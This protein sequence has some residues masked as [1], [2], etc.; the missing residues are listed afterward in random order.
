MI[1]TLRPSVLPDSKKLL[2][3]P[4]GIG[5]TLS[6]IGLVLAN[7]ILI[8]L[9]LIVLAVFPGLP[10]FFHLLFHLLVKIEIHPQKIIVTDLAGNPFVGAGWRQEIHFDHIRYMYYLGKEISL[11]RNLRARLRKF[12][13]P[14][15][16]TDYTPGN[17]TA[18][19][20]V[21][22]DL[23]RKFEQDSQ[24]TLTD[25]TAAGVLMKLDEIC[26]KYD[27]PKQ[28]QR[29]LKNDLDKDQN[30]N[31]EYVRQALSRHPLSRQD[32]QEL[33]EEFAHIDSDVVAP[34]LL[35]KVNIARYKKAETRRH[36]PSLTARTDNALVLSN[37]NGTRKVCLMHFHDLSE[38]DLRRF[39]EIIN[40]KTS[41]VRYLMADKE[42][43][44]LLR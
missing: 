26:K 39:I 32:I 19:Y 2:Y 9:P 15:A 13:I 27:I 1:Q 10:V 5:L 29:S 44:R 36:G 16:E 11:L 20:N 21:P 33:T 23:I 22:P 41:G 24:K 31:F 38:K 40:S 35:T 6:A 28:T 25:Y 14:A 42:L 12:R 4:L 30:F 7:P 8:A 18:K 3:Y 34:F 43:A 37:E 17:L